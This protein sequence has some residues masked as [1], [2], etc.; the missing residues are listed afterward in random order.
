[1]KNCE[2]DLV[3]KVYK[4]GYTHAFGVLGKAL[5]DAYLKSFESVLMGVAAGI[6]DAANEYIRSLSEQA[7]QSNDDV[8]T[9]SLPPGPC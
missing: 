9:G 7:P 3:A 4:A 6:E 2:A 1:M 5:M 8:R